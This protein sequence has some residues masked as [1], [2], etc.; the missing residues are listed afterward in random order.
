MNDGNYDILK[1]LADM[2]RLMAITAR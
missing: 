1:G 2:G